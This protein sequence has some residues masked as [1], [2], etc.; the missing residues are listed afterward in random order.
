MNITQVQYVM[1]IAKYGSFSEAALH[2]FISQPALSLQIR[3]LEKELG[4]TLFLRTSQGVSLSKA[5]EGFCE[6]A[7]P[8]INEWET[9]QQSV[10]PQSLLLHGSLRIGM[11]SRVYSNRLFDEIVRFFENHSELE[12][13]FF[14][15]A[16]QD[17]I[18]GLRSGTLD[19]ALDCLPPS[20]DAMLRDDLMTH[21]LIREPQCILMALDDPRRN[22]P[23]I[24]FSDLEGCTMMT[25]LENSIEARTLQ[26]LCRANGIVLKRVFRTDSMDTVMQLVRRG[27]GII[28]GPKSFADYYGVAAVPLT[29]YTEGTLSFICLRK[30]EKRPD[31]LLFKRYMIEICD[32]CHNDNNIKPVNK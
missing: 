28:S 22:L 26:R 23:Y 25:G 9:F 32:N 14:T 30:N 27:K 21:D 6:C 20:G 16:G 1:A 10:C 3:K 12:A 18:A 24:S 4:Y 7:Q 13:T 15:E 19:L 5:G 8:L 2:L 11:G 31:I 17:F 29:P